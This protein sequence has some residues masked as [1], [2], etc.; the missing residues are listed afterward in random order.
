MT[1]TRETLRQAAAM[2]VE[3]SKTVDKATRDLVQAWSGAWAEVADEWST[4]LDELTAAGEWP[5]RTQVF[6]A[7]RA[8]RALN[9]TVE[10]LEGLASTSG[11]RII[12]DVPVMSALGMVW[13]EQLVAS[14]WPKGEALDWA[15]VDPKALSSIVKRTTQQIEKATRRLP[16]DQSAVMKQVL[17]RGIAVGDNPRRAAALMLD[18]L[19]GVFDGGRRR[20]E[21]IAR[22][23]MLDAH[24]AAALAAR[25]ENANVLA[26]WEWQ[27][28]LDVRTCPACLSMHGRIFPV[29]A[30]GPQ[31]HQNCR[32]ASLPVVKSWRE[33]GFDMDDPKSDMP[34]A[35][36]WF[37]SQPDKVQAAIM[38]PERLRRL[39]SGDLLWDDLAV[40][41]DNP[42]WRPS[43][44][45]R[46]LEA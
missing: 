7:K 8:Q 39:R 26:G 5:T 38:G 10:A 31:G 27:A 33:L 40:R 6:R 2:R 44:V 35:E 3:V 21:T 46:P 12:Q 43:Y 36:E 15:A 18:R 16:Q 28:T 42:G 32:C 24:R 37:N 13:A 23:E 11:V 29:D 25:K 34:D 30:A 4:A 19:G 9:A 20:A 14:Q 41:R 22:T 45:V 17:V 1:V